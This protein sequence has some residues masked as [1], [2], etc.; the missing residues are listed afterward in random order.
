[1]CAWSKSLIGVLDE[2]PLAW[3]TDSIRLMYQ[4]LDGP[5]RVQGAIAPW[6][7]E[8]SLLEITRLGSRDSL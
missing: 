6:D 2:N 7:R 4:L 1:M 5:P 8:S 3:A